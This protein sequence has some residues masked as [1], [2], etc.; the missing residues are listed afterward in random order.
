MLGVEIGLCESAP[1]VIFN[2]PLD[3]QRTTCGRNPRSELPSSVP[4]SGLWG[5][6][7]EITPG[8]PHSCYHP[9]HAPAG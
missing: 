6:G 4:R 1:W 9:L 2:L 3:I 5:N 8:L 7:T